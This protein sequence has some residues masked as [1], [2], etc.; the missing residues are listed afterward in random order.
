MAAQARAGVADVEG[1]LD[2]SG[3]LRTSSPIRWRSSRTPRV[4]CGCWPRCWS[5]N[6]R[7]CCAAGA[8][9]RTNPHKRRRPVPSIGL[10][11]GRCCRPRLP[12]TSPVARRRAL[13]V[14]R[15]SVVPGRS[16]STS[17]SVRAH[18]VAHGLGGGSRRPCATPTSST[19]RARLVD[20]RLLAA[21]DGRDPRVPRTPPRLA[22]ADG[23]R[24]GA[25]GLTRSCRSSTCSSTGRSVT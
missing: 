23:R 19:T 15:M 4:R 5:A 9:D 13:G 16:S 25:R 22:Q 14:P 12:V 6:R 8:A 21:F 20:R 3:T 18:G 11:R 7:P 10:R 2:Q 1:L 17:T 24:A